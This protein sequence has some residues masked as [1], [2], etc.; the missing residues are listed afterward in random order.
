M[1]TIVTRTL[2]DHCLGLPVAK[3]ST[4]PH[5][6]LKL[7]SQYTPTPNGEAEAKFVCHTCDT[8]WLHRK[9]K[10]GSCEGFRLNP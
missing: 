10:W 7:V 5:S 4:P 3:T 6:G 2:C 8:V 9:N 1:Q